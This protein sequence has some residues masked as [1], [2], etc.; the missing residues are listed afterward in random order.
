MRTGKVFVRD[1]LAGILQETD[2]GFSLA[3]DNAY[4]QSESAPVSLRMPLRQEPYFSHSLFPFFDGL[5]PE[6]WMLEVAVDNWK[7]SSKD[8]FG[9]LLKT[10]GDP[11]GSVS[12]QEV[13]DEPV[14]AL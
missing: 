13:E 9:I 11:V 7:L 4:L 10:A 5:I 14:S 2:S 12:N 3:Y 6:G 1:R 8:R